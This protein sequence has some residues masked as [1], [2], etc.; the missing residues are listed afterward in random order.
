MI[1]GE[2]EEHDAETHDAQA[3]QAEGN[4]EGWSE[5]QRF[6]IGEAIERDSMTLAVSERG[7][8][9]E[10]IWLIIGVATPG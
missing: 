10:P 9:D 1:E 6:T 4:M 5:Q 2:A 3:A 8:Q 7:W